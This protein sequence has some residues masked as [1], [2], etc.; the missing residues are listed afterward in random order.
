[1]VSKP[2]MRLLPLLIF[3]TIAQQP[4]YPP[5][6]P[7]QPS[8]ASS[9][10]NAPSVLPNILD[11]SAPNAQDVCPGYKASNV[12]QSSTGLQADLT[13]AGTPCNVYGNDIKDLVLTV[14][15]QNQTRLAVSITPKYLAPHNESL[16]ILDERFTPKPGIEEGCSNI[17]SDLAF[18]WSNDPSFQ[19]EVT[20]VGSGETI[21]STYGKK[22]VFEDQFLELVTSMVPDYNVYGFAEAFHSFRLGNNYTQ[23]FWNAYNLD[24]DQLPDVNGHS[25]HPVYLETRYGN[26]SSTSHGVYARNAHGQDW[27]L[28]E[29]TIT[30]R[31]IGGSFELYF[32][33]GPTPKEVI[34]QYQVGIVNTPVMQA[35][36]AL[37]FHQCRWGYLNWTN[38]R[39]VVES[40][41]EAGIQLEGKKLAELPD[42]V[43]G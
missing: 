19:F 8:L 7:L 38:L 37:G 6:F 22:I 3:C 12:Q 18:T 24:N 4:Q 15:Y 30:Y 14:Q 17:T 33:S 26:G 9:Y 11:A 31:T 35:Y 34:S 32:L 43:H 1:M 41:E 21:F 23:T 36:W 39:D 10:N 40:Y 16:Y 28:R 5:A 27:L 29:D 2:R 42:S 25:T 20:R 13:L